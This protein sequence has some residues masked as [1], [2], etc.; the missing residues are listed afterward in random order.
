MPNIEVGKVTASP[1]NPKMP[2]ELSTSAFA[3][4]MSLRVT[5]SLP[6]PLTA[7]HQKFMSPDSS[8]KNYKTGVSLE[9]EVVLAL[10][11]L[12]ARSGLNR[13]WVLNT[14]V[15]EYLRLAEAN[16]TIAFPSRDAIIS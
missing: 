8:R 7:P 4:P 13:S 5:M 14:I 3:D 12:A 15:R 2:S 6:M 16:T 10:D 11:T 9:P 1:A